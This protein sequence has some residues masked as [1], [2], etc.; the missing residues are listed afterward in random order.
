MLNEDLI[1]GLLVVITKVMP[2]LVRHKNGTRHKHYV[3]TDDQGNTIPAIV[4]GTL[5]P[6]F[7]NV[8][9]L[10][11]VYT[12]S[13]AEVKPP[14]TTQLLDRYTTHWILQRRTIVRPLR[15]EER[16]LRYFIDGITPIDMITEEMADKEAVVDIMA[17]VIQVG[18]SQ[19]A[20]TQYGDG[21][22]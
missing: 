13:N 12:I 3:F 14:T 11:G 8:L 18:D 7:A 16:N 6:L 17:I 21:V 20:T 4:Y 5:I 1:I 19:T 22:V 9:S 15:Q 2:T 10:Y